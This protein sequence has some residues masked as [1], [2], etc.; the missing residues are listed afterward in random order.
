MGVANCSSSNCHGS[1]SPRSNSSVL[2]NEYITWL[3]HDRHS[4]AQ[5]ILTNADS[6]KIASHLG[7]DDPTTSKSC[8]SCHQTTPDSGATFNS[9]F[10]LEDGV[11]C[12]SC[13][14][15]AGSWLSE[16]ANLD[17]THQDNLNN[18]LIALEDPT[19]RAKTCLGCHQGDSTHQITHTI[20]GAGHPR[21]SF[22]LDTYSQLMPTHWKEDS[23]YQKRK[24]LYSNLSFW[25]AGQLQLAQSHVRSLLE[26]RNNSLF[27]EFSNFNCF[28]CHHSLESK[29]FSHRKYLNPPGIPQPNLSSVVMLSLALEALNHPQAERLKLLLSESKIIH[30]L[31]DTFTELSNLLDSITFNYS[32]SID[33]QRLLQI[34][35]SYA[36]NNTSLPYETA[37]QIVMGVQSALALEKDARYR[38]NVIS[39]QLKALLVVVQSTHGYR[40]DQFSNICAKILTA[41]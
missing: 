13:H 14:G 6:K 32:S 2:Q 3:K 12:E 9:K 41:I 11:S 35:L 36:K 4:Q 26:L 16:H 31:P 37:E 25:L 38:K 15:A 17:T 8:T 7:I 27:P 10:R 40:S 1:M 5:K 30:Q 33:S 34:L 24:S 22:E 23:D 28:S 18:G 39:S 20:Y 29:E 21:L 19:I